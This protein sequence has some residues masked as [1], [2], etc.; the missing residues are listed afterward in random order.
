MRPMPEIFTCSSCGG[1]DFAEDACFRA[2]V[3]YEIANGEEGVV[4]TNQGLEIQEELVL[5]CVGCSAASVP[6]ED[7]IDWR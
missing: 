3:F 6:P 5:T 4:F 2:E 7:L 1:T